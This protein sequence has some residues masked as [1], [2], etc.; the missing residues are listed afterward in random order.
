MQTDTSPPPPGF[1]ETYS[2]HRLALLR[3]AFL[4]SG[5]H[6]TSVPMCGRSGSA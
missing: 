3:L 4:V 5:S 1:E 2:D 6:E